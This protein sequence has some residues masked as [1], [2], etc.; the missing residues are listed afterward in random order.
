MDERRRLARGLLPMV[1][2][3]A[4]RAEAVRLAAPGQPEKR[5]IR[6]RTELRMSLATAATLRRELVT[7]LE[8]KDYTQLDR[9]RLQKVVGDLDEDIAYLERTRVNCFLCRKPVIGSEHV[10]VWGTLTWHL[11]P[12]LQ[13][14][15]HDVA[16]G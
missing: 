10:G 12:C 3:D 4:I 5:R 15:H 9:Q 13:E 6:R 7:L 8:I 1:V 2:P 11:F 16:A 14:T